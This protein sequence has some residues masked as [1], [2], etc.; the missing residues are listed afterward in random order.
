MAANPSAFGNAPA[1]AAGGALSGTYPNPT[2]NT[3]LPS[4]NNLLMAAGDPWAATTSNLMIAGTLYLIKL[5][6][7][8]SVPVTNI[9]AL[10]AAA[11]SGASTGSFA[12]LYSSAGALLSGSADVAG[13]FT[14]A[15]SPLTLS[16]STPQ[17]V[18]AGAF[19]WAALLSN[20]ATTQPQLRSGV[21]STGAVANIGLT[22]AAA[23]WATNGTGLAALPGSIT[24]AS[25]STSG[26][27][28]W[29][30]AS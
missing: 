10:L 4:D 6:A 27:T 5:K 8:T 19:V 29:A 28:F 1:G 11:G 2:I 7:V 12:G 20:L 24:P 14:G 3:W 16:L 21:G 15:A 26:L 23:R 30:G 25:N 17:P 22:P 9:L 13:S 18:A